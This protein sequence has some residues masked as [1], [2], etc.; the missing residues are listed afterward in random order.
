VAL[1]LFHLTLA[2][3]SGW[4]LSLILL[5]NGTLA[6]TTNAP[7]SSLVPHAVGTVFALAILLFCPPIRRAGLVWRGGAPLWSFLGG[8]SGAVTVIATS[9]AMNSVLALSGTLA[10]GLVGQGI[11]A[12][13]ADRYGLLGL[14]K[15]RTGWQGIA[16]LVLILAGSGFVILGGAT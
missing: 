5:F 13:L 7:F 10:L 1:Y 14:P 8:V 11:F 3:A 2:F 4:L 12:L 16:A 6:T 15:R 9:I